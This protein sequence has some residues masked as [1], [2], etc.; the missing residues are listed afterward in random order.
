[1]LSQNEIRL[2]QIF[3]CDKFFDGK[4]AILDGGL[5]QLSPVQEKSVYNHD[6]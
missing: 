6:S 3:V 4:S 1:M 2:R 5:Y